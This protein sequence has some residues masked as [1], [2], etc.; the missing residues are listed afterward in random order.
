MRRGEVGGTFGVR[1]GN[2]ADRRTDDA[3][4][5]AAGGFVVVAVAGD[6][7]ETGDRRV[8]GF[9]VEGGGALV[10]D[11]ADQFERGVDV[12][13][14]GPK[15]EIDDAGG[16]LRGDVGEALVVLEPG[17][18]ALLV[19]RREIGNRGEHMGR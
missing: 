9:G 5:G 4:S 8:L 15:C 19:Q 13:L 2:R 11:L 16:E 6:L 18:E 12:G 3:V 17:A 14:G 1:F 10:G 7:V